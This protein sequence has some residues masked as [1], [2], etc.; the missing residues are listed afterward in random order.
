MLTYDFENVKEPLYEYIY[1]CIKSDI[2]SGN[3]KPGEKLP[4]KRTFA[5]NNGI[6]TITIQNAYDQLI[7]EG[8]VYSLPKKGY[9]V[10]DID[11]RTSTPKEAKITLDIKL[12]EEKAVYDIDL[13]N[14]EINPDNFPFSIWAKLSREI[15]SNKKKELMEASPT[16]GKYEVRA[17]IAEHLKSFRGMLVD[18][19]QIVIGAGTEYLYGLIIQLLG[20]DKSYCIEN[21][22]YKK[23]LQIYKQ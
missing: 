14:N 19:N 6:S 23:L 11:V 22:G 7:S 5:H 12:P 16:G 13:S 15:I 4:S 18:P 3:L 1:K 8:Y 20:K 21:P 10:A 9:F 2:V 17:A